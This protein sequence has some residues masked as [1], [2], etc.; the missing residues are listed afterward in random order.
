MIVESIKKSKFIIRGN[1]SSVIEMI[2]TV[3][4]SNYFSCMFSIKYNFPR[5]ETWFLDVFQNKCILQFAIS[6]SFI[7][8]PNHHS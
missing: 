7:N 2:I 5:Y 6:Q 8:E 1:L 3:Q 4:I